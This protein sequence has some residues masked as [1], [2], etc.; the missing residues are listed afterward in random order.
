MSEEDRQK[1][2]GKR[3]RGGE[4]GGRDHQLQPE[5]QNQWGALKHLQSHPSEQKQKDGTSS[6]K[7]SQTSRNSK[8]GK[9]KKQKN[10]RRDSFEVI[11]ALFDRMF[12]FFFFGLGG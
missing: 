3:E 9:Q 2:V 1:R 6:Q 7:G 11:S 10:T 12:S 8:T 5:T 4:G